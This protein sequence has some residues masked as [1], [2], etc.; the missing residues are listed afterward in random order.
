MRNCLRFS[1]VRRIEF[2]TYRKDTV[3]TRIPNSY[4][5]RPL[6]Y[7]LVILLQ[8]TDLLNNADLDPYFER[9][10]SQ[11]LSIDPSHPVKA[12]KR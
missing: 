11:G 12:A 5:I 1:L 7:W 8:L 4:I 10:S 2:Q 3:H 6:F 9:T